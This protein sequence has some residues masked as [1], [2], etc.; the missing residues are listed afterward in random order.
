MQQCI[1]TILYEYSSYHTGV[2]ALCTLWNVLTVTNASQVT[3]IY[4]VLFTIQI[5]S[6]QLHSDNMKII[7]Q[8]L[9]LEENCVIVH[10]K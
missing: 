8:S 10:L 4:I 5:V 6:K 2:N 1:F 9:F 7:L 3:F